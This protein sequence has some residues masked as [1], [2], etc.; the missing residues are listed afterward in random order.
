[1][2]LI[3]ESSDGRFP[4]HFPHFP[5]S[6]ASIVTD[7]GFQDASRA[8]GWHHHPRR[9]TEIVCVYIGAIGTLQL[10]YYDRD[11]AGIVAEIYIALLGDRAVHF[12]DAV[13]SHLLVMPWPV[14]IWMDIR[15]VI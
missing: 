9:G 11:S 3:G 2:A 4:R 13:P 5:L 12:A 10:R 1:M 14:G 8:A 6:Q 15:K 7:S